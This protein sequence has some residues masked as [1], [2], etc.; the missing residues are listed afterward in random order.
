MDEIFT[1][2]MP[3]C[4]GCPTQ[5]EGFLNET[6]QAFYFRYRG[7]H[8]SL[9]V[10]FDDRITHAS[11]GSAVAAYFSQ[12]RVT[13]ADWLGCLPER[14]VTQRVEAWLKTYLALRQESPQNDQ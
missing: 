5:A 9:C 4:G 1:Y 8:A 2:T 11:E 6:G 7:G 14:A 10:S 3:P 12:S 13:G